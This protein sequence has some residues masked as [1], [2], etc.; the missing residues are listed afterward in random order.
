MLCPYCQTS[1]TQELARTTALGY[2][3]VFPSRFR[4]DPCCA[5]HHAASPWALPRTVAH[6][7]PA[8]QRPRLGLLRSG[9]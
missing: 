7:A 2:I 5:A 8:C 4:V 6:N 3:T 1:A 9:A